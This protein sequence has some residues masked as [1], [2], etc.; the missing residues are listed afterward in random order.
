M[1]GVFLIA[2]GGIAIII[3]LKKR[4]LKEQKKLEEDLIDLDEEDDEKE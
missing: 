4:K 1:I 2:A 3:S